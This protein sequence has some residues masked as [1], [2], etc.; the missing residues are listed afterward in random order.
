MKWC[1]PNAKVIP[2][3][4][5]NEGLAELRGQVPM[6]CFPGFRGPAR[7][8]GTNETVDDLIS[9][10]PGLR[11]LHFTTEEDSTVLTQSAVAMLEQLGRAFPLLEDFN[12]DLCQSDPEE[13]KF[14]LG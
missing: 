11:E 12:I 13:V 9:I 14:F 2:V 7:L 4:L 1:R 5:Y 8:Q 3:P 10:F 6:P